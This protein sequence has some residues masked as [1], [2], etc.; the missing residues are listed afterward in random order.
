MPDCS[1]LDP[2]EIR[3]T[4]LRVTALGTRDALVNSIGPCSRAGCRVPHPFHSLIV[5]RVGERRSRRSETGIKHCRV[6]SLQQGN[7]VARMAPPGVVGVV[8]GA[9]VSL[10]SLG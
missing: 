9:L 2:F 6:P 7:G 8:G 4:H 3:V 5:E 10:A 1:G